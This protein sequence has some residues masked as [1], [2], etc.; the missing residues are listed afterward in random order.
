MIQK[1]YVIRYGFFTD[2]RLALMTN[3][4]KCFE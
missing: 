1:K 3:T 2:I 4:S